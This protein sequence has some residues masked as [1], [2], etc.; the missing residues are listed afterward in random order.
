MALVGQRLERLCEG[1]FGLTEIA[2]ETDEN[3]HLTG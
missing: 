2:A 1:R 3:L